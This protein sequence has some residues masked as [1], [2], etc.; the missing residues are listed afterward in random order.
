MKILTDVIIYYDIDVVKKL[1]SEERY[2]S[3]IEQ[4]GKLWMMNQLYGF[5]A[6]PL[7]EDYETFIKAVLICA[8]GDGVLPAFL[9]KIAITS[10]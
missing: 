10:G 4:D 5:K 9:T 7:D 3:D 1:E 6:I 8:K 2:M